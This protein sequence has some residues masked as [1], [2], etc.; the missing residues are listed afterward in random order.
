[1]EEGSKSND[2]LMN[3]ATKNHDFDS[4]CT[5][6]DD[7]NDD[8]EANSE[9]QY[10]TLSLQDNSVDLTLSSSLIPNKSGNVM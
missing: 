2:E 4:Y 3:A 8:L 5:S 1:M 10:L 6:N 7:N 9:Q